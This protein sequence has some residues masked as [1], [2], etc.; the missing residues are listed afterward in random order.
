[1]ND[2]NNKQR[3]IFGISLILLS[4]SGI[5][6]AV[7]LPHEARVPGGLAVIKLEDGTS[8]P[9]P[10]IQAYFHEQPVMQIATDKGL[11]AVVGIPLSARPGHQQHLVIK[12]SGQQRTLDFAIKDKAYRTQRLTIKN[13]RKV[14]PNAQD[15]QRIRRESQR[16]KQALT[17]WSDVLP[18]T[19]HLEA[20]VTGIRS[21]SFGARRVF[22][23]HPRRPHS[24][25]D[26]AAAEGTPVY[27]PAAGTVI[28]TGDYFFNGNTVFI[29]HGQ[30]LV[31]IYCHLSQISVDEGQH[32]KAGELIGK[33][34]ETG[35]VTGPH[36]H[37][38]VSLNDA[39]IDP[40][41][42]LDDN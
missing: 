37:W 7:E 1:M 34:G 32:L 9:E 5:C 33:V 23:G 24:G 12:Q 3:H 15:M 14:T 19:L 40:A 35:R 42:L 26:I 10:A 20:P 4:L 18:Q 21:D 30:G 8:G 31:T 22:N 38:G 41:L 29:D 2:S 39:R 11:Y 17:H 13:K 6:R 27:S 25:M 36:L 16:I 28:N